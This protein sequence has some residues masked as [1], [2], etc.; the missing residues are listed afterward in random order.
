M[1]S[2]FIL[3]CAD[4]A[5]MLDT[6]SAA[7]AD[8]QGDRA[9]ANYRYFADINGESIRLTNVSHDGSVKT[10]PANFTGTTPDGAKLRADRRIEFKS[11]PSRHD[12]DSRCTGA[13]GRVMKCE[14]SCGGKNH[15]KV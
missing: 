10:S 5:L 15:G 14:C 8:K 3:Q 13:R 7:G 9:M 12:C 6:R 4:T 11:N 1:T 2:L